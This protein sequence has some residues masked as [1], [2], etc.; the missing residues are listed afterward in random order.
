MTFS[1][2]LSGGNTFYYAG[3]VRTIVDV[4][5][6]HSRMLR[7]NSQTSCIPACCTRLQAVDIAHDICSGVKYLLY[8]HAKLLKIMSA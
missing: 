8:A 1:S 2:L 5:V 7:K 3:N 4:S 6:S